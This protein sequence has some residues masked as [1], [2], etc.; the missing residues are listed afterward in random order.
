MDGDPT[1]VMDPPA[2]LD[3]AEATARAARGLTN[4]AP[5]HTSRTVAA[6][7]RANLFTRFNAILGTLLVVILTVGPI[8]DALF[9]IVL[10]TNATIGV[11]QEWRA[12]R[13]LDRL[14]LVTAPTITIVRSGRTRPVGVGDVVLGDTVALAPGTQVVADGTVIASDGLEVDES[15]LTGESQPEPKAAGAAVLSGSFV[16]AGRGWFRADRVGADAYAARL[17]TEARRFSLVRSELRQGIDQ[18]LRLVTW[19][20]PPTA[21]LLVWSQL[22]AHESLPEAIRGSVA[23]LGAMV[24]EGLVL[25]TSVAFAAA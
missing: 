6:I 5:A 16:T 19:L 24:P 8:Q 13:T 18:I 9:G 7:L 14:A 12:K 17:A 11:I 15:L 4:R 23:G 20:L 21:V 2:G 1:P 25:L 10:V 22:L 3:E